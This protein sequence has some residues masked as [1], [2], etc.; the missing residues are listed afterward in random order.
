[1]SSTNEP[2]EEEQDEESDDEESAEQN[3]SAVSAGLFEECKMVR[4]SF[5][6]V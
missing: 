4:F 3:F 2:R 1:M 6:V 5:F